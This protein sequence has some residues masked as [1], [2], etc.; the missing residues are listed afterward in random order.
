[1]YFTLLT[2]SEWT[3]PKLWYVTNRE[4]EDKSWK[5]KGNKNKFIRNKGTFTSQMFKKEY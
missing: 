5:N 3:W 4:C 1:M 2:Q